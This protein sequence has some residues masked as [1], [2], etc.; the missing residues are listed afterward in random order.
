MKD[1]PNIWQHL[2]D[3]ESY[4]FSPHMWHC[5][6]QAYQDFNIMLNVIDD[7]HIYDVLLEPSAV[8]AT[9][10][11]S[12]WAKQQVINSTLPEYCCLDYNLLTFQ[13]L[14]FADKVN[15]MYRKN[16][17]L[18]DADGFEVLAYEN[19]Q[20][21]ILDG[22]CVYGGFLI[23]IRMQLRNPL[24]SQRFLHYFDIGVFKLTDECKISCHPIL[25]TRRGWMEIEKVNGIYMVV[26]C[27]L[28]TMTLHEVHFSYEKKQNSKIS[29]RTKKINKQHD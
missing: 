5:L 29:K 17:K 9:V 28:T 11:I 18:C 15:L 2:P 1:F 21:I 13:K 23:F 3:V 26:S 27:D 6:M 4:R 24:K 8:F 12:F 20:N 10:K 14:N 7:I 16:N 25:D 22:R 19:H